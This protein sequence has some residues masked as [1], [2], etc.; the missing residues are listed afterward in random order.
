MLKP[1]YGNEL[2]FVMGNIVASY[3]GQ[4]EKK[5]QL[6]PTGLYGR[7]DTGGS[8][9]MDPDAIS[10]AVDELD[11]GGGPTG[12]P[13]RFEEA[14]GENF[15]DA[16]GEYSPLSFPKPKNEIDSD[17][18]DEINA[19]LGPV[20]D[21]AYD[22]LMDKPE[23]VSGLEEPKPLIMPGDTLIREYPKDGRVE[24]MEFEDI[25]PA[26]L[27]R[28][29]T[30]VSLEGEDVEDAVPA[31]VPETPYSGPGGE[32]MGIR[33]PGPVPTAALVLDRIQ[34]IATYLGEKGDVRSEL[35]ADKLL[36]SAIS[37]LIK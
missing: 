13:S 27:F 33:G 36:H 12:L 35:I 2:A 20:K 7:E 30:S 8:V 25:D 9:D 14:T 16:R 10:N 1:K 15:G 18:E 32:G 22:A 21:M 11:S 29:P 19:E 5:A 37:K 17:S 6:S 34:K 23:A 28:Y 31:D 4:L 24:E 3:G 26:N